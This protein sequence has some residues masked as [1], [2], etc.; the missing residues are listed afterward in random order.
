MVPGHAKPSLMEG[1]R[2]ATAVIASEIEWREVDLPVLWQRRSRSVVQEEA[3]R[4][5]P[6]L[7]QAALR[8]GRTQSEGRA[9]AQSEDCEVVRAI[10][11][12]LRAG[13]REGLGLSRVFRQ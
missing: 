1:R 5:L 10:E 4:A 11:I 3:G 7:L 13:L 9:H 2:S 6:R 12:E 8:F